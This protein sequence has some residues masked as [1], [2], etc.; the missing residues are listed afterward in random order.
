MSY[1][2][3]TGA[4]GLLGRY[5]LRNL[6]VAEE[7]V[8]VVVRPGKLASARER[9]ELIMQR[10]EAIEG[11]ALPRPIV[12]VGD[13][14]EPGLGLSEA[15][16]R[17]IAENC[18]AVLH[19]AASMIFRAQDDGEPHRTNVEGTRNV[20]ELCRRAGIAEFHHVSTAYL[21]GMRQGRI[22]ETE[23]DEGQDPGNVYEASKLAGEKIVRE[24][25]WL[26]WLTVYRPA[27]I[28]GDSRD[29]YTTSYHGFYLPLQL[30]YTMSGR[31]PPEQMGERFFARLGLSGDE[32]KNLVPIEWVATAICEILLN[33]RLHGGTYHLASP[34]P[35]TVRL[36]QR[37]IQDSIRRYS[38]R[39]TATTATEAD[40]AGCE[41]L[42]HHHMQVYQSHWRDDPNFDRTNTDRAL[43][44]LPCPPLDYD[45]LLTIARFAIEQSFAS[46]KHQEVA[47][48][49]DV[50][51]WLRGAVEN[52]RDL[53]QKIAAPRLNLQVN[54]PGGGQWLLHA[55]DDGQFQALPGVVDEGQALCYCAS[56]ALGRIARGELTWDAALRRGQVVLECPPR[57]RQRMT[58]LLNALGESRSTV[59]ERKPAPRRTKVKSS[60]GARIR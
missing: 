24:A 16:E 7:H 43:P 53:A 19:N 44:H 54:G 21:C 12:L 6:L 46:P 36:M 4:T 32:G 39:R 58:A 37:V 49:F 57:D 1:L 42:F 45:R 52:L 25:S 22:L 50:E 20:V 30:A 14:R 48:H 3:L 34:A 13:L 15:D 2:L 56:A 11:R 18:G 29:G 47:A 33:E 9:I 35:V 26:K 59:A 51:A 40:L 60:P 17:W 41:R 28:V 8:A 31:I 55:D 27:S 10:W 23:L 38:Q 5:V